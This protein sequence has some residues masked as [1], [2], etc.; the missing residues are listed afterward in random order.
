MPGRVAGGKRRGRRSA[1]DPWELQGRAAEIDGDPPALA[2]PERIAP[3]SPQ[4]AKDAFLLAW[5]QC[6]FNPA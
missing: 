6:A 4:A 1:G 3:L 2:L 5:A